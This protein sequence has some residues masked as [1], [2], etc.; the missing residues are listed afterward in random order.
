MA[1]QKTNNYF[2][3]NKVE[4]VA[5]EEDWDADSPHKE[6]NP[7]V[8]PAAEFYNRG[9]NPYGQRPTTAAMGQQRP[10]QKVA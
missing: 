8:E 1:P 3:K 9:A 5:D 4:A 6:L 2:D 7:K 10:V